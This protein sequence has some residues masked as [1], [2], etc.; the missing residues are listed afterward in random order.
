M[1]NGTDTTD[2]FTSLAFLR[3]TMKSPIGSFT[4]Q[5]PRRFLNARNV[6]FKRF[7]TEANAAHVEVTHKSAWATTLEAATNNPTFEF[8][9]ALRFHDH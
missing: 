2:L 4:I 3:R 7:F 9:L 6:A 8:R 5:L 1:E